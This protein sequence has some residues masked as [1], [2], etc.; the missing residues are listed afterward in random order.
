MEQDINAFEAARLAGVRKFIFP[1]T[2][3]TV[4][5]PDGA[6][7]LVLEV[8]QRLASGRPVAI[9]DRQEEYTPQ[10]AAVFLNVSRTY[11]RRLMDEGVLP[12]RTVGSHHRI[13]FDD[14]Q[15]YRAAETARSRKALDELY[16]LES[17]MGLNDFE[18]FDTEDGADRNGSPR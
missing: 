5:L 4:P 3:Q 6:A 12:F 13:P 10:Q 18:P 1:S 17:R 7:R 8:L 9:S 2:G 16:E 14:L 11:V 15:V